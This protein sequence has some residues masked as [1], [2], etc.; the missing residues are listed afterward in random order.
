MIRKASSADLER[1]EQLWLYSVVTAHPSLPRSY[2][3]ARLT[4]FRRNCLGASSCLVYCEGRHRA[5]DGFAVVGPDRALVFLCV[6][7]AVSRRGGGGELM[8]AAKVGRTEM[9]ATV[10]QENLAGRYFLQ[11]HGFVETERL[12]CADAGQTEIVMRYSARRADAA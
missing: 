5:A 3:Q 9:H 10:L 6:T 11:R 4:A 8:R 1:M 2:W 12:P 7:P